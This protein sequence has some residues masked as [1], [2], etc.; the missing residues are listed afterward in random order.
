MPEIVDTTEV[1]MERELVVYRLE[2]SNFWQCRFKVGGVWQRASTKERDLTKA[3]AKAKDLMIE[4]EIRK[5]SNLPVIPASFASSQAM[6]LS[7]CS[8]SRL[9]RPGF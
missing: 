6:L 1:L 9:N 4:A 3:K 2:R 7:V 8:R 5:R